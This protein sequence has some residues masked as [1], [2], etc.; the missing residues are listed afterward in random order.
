MSEPGPL[1]SKQLE[2]ERTVVVKGSTLEGGTLEGGTLE[3]ATLASNTEVEKTQLYDITSDDPA[4][5][6]QREDEATLLARIK[7]GQVLSGTFEIISPLGRGGMSVVYKARHL[8]MNR[9]V[10]LKILL[11]GRELDA[12]S[13]QRFQQEALAA[14]KLDHPAIVKV[15]DF[16]F[17]HELELPYLVMDYVEGETLSTRLSAVD[18][19]TEEKARELIGK[20]AEALSHAHERNV[21][22]RDIKP[23]NIILTKDNEGQD[24]VNILDFGIAKI[25]D[26]DAGQLTITQTGEIFGSPNYMSPEQCLGQKLDTRSD[27]YSLGCVL[28][29]CLIGA[30]PFK[31]ES[32]IETMMLH[33]SQRSVDFRG[34]PVSGKLQ[35]IILKCLEK[36]PEK[37]FQSMQELSD[38]LLGKK[39][40]EASFG[41]RI[42]HYQRQLK[43]SKLRLVLSA[44]AFIVIFGGTETLMN[45]LNDPQIGQD[46][47]NNPDAWV[48]LADKLEA[49][50]KTEKAI[51]A[52][53]RALSISPNHIDAM[54]RLSRYYRDSKKDYQT[55][56]KYLLDVL[57]IVP[58]D[59]YARENLVY[60]YQK[61]STRLLDEG[62]PQ[63]AFELINKAM[64]LKPKDDSL[65]FQMGD[66]QARLGKT[67]DALGWFETAHEMEP[68]NK[69]YTQRLY[70]ELK[71]SG[72]QE[73]LARLFPNGAPTN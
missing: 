30:P 57:K 49:K 3:S 16:G 35:N 6:K 33:L 58:T 39:H 42:E 45:Y 71:K 55:A 52:A 54:L 69:R 21:I 65:I 37:R 7:P 17:D 27:I 61:M 24:A 5:L 25:T 29:E 56:N 60:N 64:E 51:A 50:A 1:P 53:N 48:A 62:K 41:T 44:V 31:S 47:T 66:I 19:L 10:A 40:V 28:F 72:D 20:L 8:L 59:S 2:D 4:S 22:H 70:D 43:H 68:H 12:R 15:Y 14:A 34:K 63:E 36:E 18:I 26:Q 32:P 67:V 9:L 46:E 73:R 13:L 38:A 11:P 23:A